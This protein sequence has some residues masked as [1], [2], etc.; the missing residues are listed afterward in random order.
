MR[1]IIAEIEGLDRIAHRAP[2]DLTLCSLRIEH[3][4]CFA[5]SAAEARALGRAEAQ[6]R[7]DDEMRGLQEHLDYMRTG[8]EP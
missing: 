6:A 4:M 5:A 3:V 8:E 7:M 2:Y 1:T